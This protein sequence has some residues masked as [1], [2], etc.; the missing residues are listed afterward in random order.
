VLS[1]WLAGENSTMVLPSPGAVTHEFDE[2]DGRPAL[3]AGL[4]LR[5]PW[6]IGDLRL[7]YYD[8]LGDQSVR[9]VW[10]TRYGVAG[11]AVQP[12]PGLDVIFQYLIGET[13]TRATPSSYT[14][15]ALY[16]LLSYRWRNHR[17]T[18]RYDDFRVEDH[19]GETGDSN[20]RGEAVTIAYLF[21]FWLRHRLAF[22]YIDVDRH[23]SSAAQPEP[24]GN[25]L[26]V[27]YR[28]TY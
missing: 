7:G 24:S 6:K 20:D 10:Q 2:R 4:D 9:G 21:E 15:Q 14:I 17:L 13:A 12:L 16:P 11:I 22:E 23:H 8:N 25:Q 26:Q 3:Y 5:D 27:S 18:V 1:D 19:D 28:F